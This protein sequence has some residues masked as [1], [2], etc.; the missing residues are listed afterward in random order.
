MPGQDQERRKIKT[1]F[2]INGGFPKVTGA[3]DCTHMKIR[4]PDGL[5]AERFRTRKKYFSINV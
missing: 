5:N 2:H 1:E 4:S 3:V